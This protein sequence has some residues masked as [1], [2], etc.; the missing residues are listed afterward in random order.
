MADDAVLELNT[1]NWV[2]E[3]VSSGRPVLVDFWGPG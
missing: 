2:R 1:D 3:V